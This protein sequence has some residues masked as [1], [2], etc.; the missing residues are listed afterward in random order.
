MKINLL[1]RFYHP[2]CPPCRI[3]HWSKELVALPHP[4][5][6]IG[7]CIA[8]GCKHHCL[9][10]FGCSGILLFLEHRRGVP[11]KEEG[12]KRVVPCE[13]QEE[14]LNYSIE[15]PLAMLPAICMLSRRFT[16]ESR[17]TAK[18]SLFSSLIGILGCDLIVSGL[19]GLP[20]S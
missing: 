16:R 7:H 4:W 14:T 19:M 5:C 10:T 15:S 17:T 3:L 6:S 20:F 13:P 2:F 12:R 18:A 1:Q 9:N 8:V 11:T